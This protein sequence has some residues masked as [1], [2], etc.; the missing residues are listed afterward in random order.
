MTR[1]QLSAEID[2][3]MQKFVYAYLITSTTVQ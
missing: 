2:A 1:Q 3:Y